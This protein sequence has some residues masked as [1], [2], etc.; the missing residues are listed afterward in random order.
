MT[1][2]VSGRYTKRGEYK[3]VIAQVPDAAAARSMDLVQRVCE[4]GVKRGIY[5]DWQNAAYPDVTTARSGLMSDFGIAWFN[6]ARSR[7]AEIAAT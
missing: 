1:I 2:V 4:A 5:E 7:L 6:V 3:M